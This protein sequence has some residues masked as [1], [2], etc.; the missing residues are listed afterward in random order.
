VVSC[1]SARCVIWILQ[2]VHSRGGAF[3]TLFLGIASRRGLQC[4]PKQLLCSGSCIGSDE[5]QSMQ[6]NLRPP[7]FTSMNLIGL[8]HFLQAGG[9]AFLAIG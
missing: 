9:G 5:S 6:R 4:T 7:V 3:G 2:T 1:R 8:P